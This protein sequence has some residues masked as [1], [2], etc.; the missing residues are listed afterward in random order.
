METSHSK[1]GKHGHAKVH[2]IG[3]DIFTGRKYEDVVPSTHNVE[4]PNIS[5]IEM[6]LVS[7]DDEGF[8]TLMDES[9][10]LKEDLRIPEDD[11]GEQIRKYFEEGVD[12]LVG[13]CKAMGEEK[14]LSVKE[15]R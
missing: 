4:V 5:R 14:I 6:Q 12:V 11:V 13:I 3:I 9:G 1:T 15:M 8:A 2:M 7:I 10:D